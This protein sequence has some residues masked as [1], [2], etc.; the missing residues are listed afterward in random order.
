M[1]EP[2]QN[3][4]LSEGIVPWKGRLHFQVYNPSKIIKY[5]VLNRILKD[6]D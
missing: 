5:G 4:L 1:Y 6:P 2:E 3:L